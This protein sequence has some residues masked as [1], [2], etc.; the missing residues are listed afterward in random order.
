V[1]IKIKKKKKKL[2]RQSVYKVYKIYYTTGEYYIG[3]TSKTG[4]AFN[5][6]WGSNSTTLIHS[7]KDVIYITHNKSDAKLVE[8]LYQLQSFYKKDCLNKMLHVRLRRD[9]IKK[10]PKFQVDI[11]E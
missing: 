5:N 4:N 1:N 6:Y 3:L 2:K 11:T 7:Y 9:F 10:I 8:L